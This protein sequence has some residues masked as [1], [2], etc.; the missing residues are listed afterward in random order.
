MYIMPRRPH[1]GQR[2][3]VEKRTPSG[4]NPWKKLG[5]VSRRILYHSVLSEGL[6]GLG[7]YYETT[8]RVSGAWVDLRGAPGA[9]RHGE[10]REPPFLHLDLGPKPT[11]L[12]TYN[13]RVCVY[14]YIYIL[15]IYIY[16]YIYIYMYIYIY[17]Y[18]HLLR[19]LCVNFPLRSVCSSRFPLGQ[20]V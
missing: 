10:G 16:I 12:Y 11:S 7:F 8:L 3:K 13:M 9:S 18:T 17:L 20:D 5:P 4:P 15:Y 1:G 2:E 6:E 14:I 19:Y